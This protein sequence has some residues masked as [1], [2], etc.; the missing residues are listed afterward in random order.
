MRAKRTLRRVEQGLQEEVR[1]ARARLERLEK[2]VVLQ[3]ERALQSEARAAIADA[4]YR[5]GL[6]DNFD[7]LEAATEERGARIALASAEADRVVAVHELVAAR[8][9]YLD[10]FEASF[11]LNLRV[12]AGLEEPGN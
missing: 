2:S 11:G 6:A 4:R 9:G 1:N 8:G 7:L 5:N 3:G 12:L 10:W